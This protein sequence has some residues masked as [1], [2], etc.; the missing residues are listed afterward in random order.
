M[1]I[2]GGPGGT[3]FKGMLV[4]GIAMAGCAVFL[5]WGVPASAQ[6][7]T[8]TIGTGSNSGVYIQLG[9]AICDIVRREMRGT[10]CRAVTSTGSID[11]LIGIKK[12]TFDLGIVQSDVQYHAVN[13]TGTFANIGAVKGIY[14]LF[15][16]H[17]E[18][19]AIVTKKGSGIE[20]LDDLSGN[21]IDIGKVKSGTNAT[22]RLLFEAMG[23]PLSS[24]PLIATL[25][26]KDQYGAICGH[27]V[28]ATAFLAGHPNAG[29][30]K[31][32]K[33]CDIGFVRADGV[34]VDRL[35]ASNPYY[36]R[37]LISKDSYDGM[38]EDVPTVGLVATVMA[39]DKLDSTTAYFLTKAVFEN[40]FFI[41]SKHRAFLRL[42][43]LEMAR[44][45]MTAPRHPGA[46]Q[47]LREVGRLP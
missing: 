26:V 5:T 22:M 7:K 1:A 39:S 2:Q 24:F 8:L 14:S 20:D 11:N 15:S 4:N 6:A 32:I 42:H 12:G 37:A 10:Q 25:D 31:L 29:I 27:Q 9:K 43:P 33:L 13:G 23:K 28:D 21:R 46:E 47:Y 41:H 40:L 17:P 3:R 44:K 19:L 18:S 30:R 38:Q 45:G 16:A 36:V 35:L 34:A